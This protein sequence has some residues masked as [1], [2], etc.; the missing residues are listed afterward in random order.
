MKAILLAISCLSVQ[1]LLAAGDE[2][3]DKLRSQLAKLIP[4]HQPSYIKAAPLPGF[5]EVAYGAQIVYLSADGRYVL[6]G[7]ILDLE[8]KADL[9]EQAR[10]GIRKAMLAKEDEKSMIVFSP[11]KPKHTVTVFTDVDCGYCRAMHREIAAYNAQGIKVRY[12]MFPRGGEDSAGYKTAI[13][14]W[15]AAD[16][17]KALTKAKQGSKVEK[18]TCDNPIDDQL[19]L[20]IDL[21]VRGTPTMVLENGELLVGYKSPSELALLLDQ[22]TSS[23]GPDPGGNTASAAH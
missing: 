4:D 10:G 7:S 18:K 13:N 15:C 21:G 3:S 1:P 12:L 14:V 23:A 8:A 20:G 22:V 9:T 16:R 6:Q 11:A 19:E 5:Y 17:N 2:V